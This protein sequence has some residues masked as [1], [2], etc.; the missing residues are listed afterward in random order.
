LTDAEL[1]DMEHLIEFSGGSR[2]S[3]VEI[4]DLY[5]TQTTEQLNR[6]ET[7]FT[8]QDA[9]AVARIAHSSAG[10]S[11]VCGILAMESLFRRVERLGK[12]NNVA[13]AATLLPELR[14]NFERVKALLLN[15]RQNLPLS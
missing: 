8:E 9:A 6:L 2:T 1:I 13:D 15:S 5:F 11:G 7:A 4:T 3:L 14:Q 10:A 12:E